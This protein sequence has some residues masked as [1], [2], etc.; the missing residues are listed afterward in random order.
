MRV[1]GTPSL[2][3]IQSILDGD[4]IFRPGS[5]YCDSTPYNSPGSPSCSNAISV[6]GK[7]VARS[8]SPGASN[9]TLELPLKSSLL[10]PIESILPNICSIVD[11]DPSGTS[12]VTF[13]R[14]PSFRSTIKE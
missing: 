11:N 8:P 3:S 1:I 10:I 5:E 4:H 14:P 2:E 9:T 12:S 13:Q 6:L 7:R